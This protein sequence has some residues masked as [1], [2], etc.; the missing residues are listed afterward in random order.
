M[1]TAGASDANDTWA[2]SAPVAAP[3]VDA[4][5]PS[6]VDSSAAALAVLDA[7]D[8]LPSASSSSID[9]E[10]TGALH[11]ALHR[12]LASPRVFGHAYSSTGGSAPSPKLALHFTGSDGNC[13]AILGSSWSCGGAA[14]TGRG[15]RHL[16]PLRKTIASP[17]V[18]AVPAHA[19]VLPALTEGIGDDHSALQAVGGA[20]PEAAAVSARAFTGTAPRWSTGTSRVYGAVLGSSWSHGGTAGTGRGS[21]HLNP[22]S[23]TTASLPVGAVPAHATVHPA[24]TEGIGDDHSALQAAGDAAPE[25][26][27]ASARAFTDSAPR[28]STGTSRVHLR[29]MRSRAQVPTL[30]KHSG[31]RE[32]SSCGGHTARRWLR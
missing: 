27:A 26:A 25:A 12:A 19:T 17:P 1:T 32:I 8:T 31:T 20:A 5:T 16:P 24:P 22:L 30:T 15:F 11:G 29:A 14:V 13:G 3:T 23:K 2:P 7:A 28:W 4:S 21:S 18:D 9:A 10:G 6:G